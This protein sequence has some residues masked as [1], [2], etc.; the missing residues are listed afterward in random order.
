M[1]D[2]LWGRWPRWSE[3]GLYSYAAETRVGQ[4]ANLIRFGPGWNVTPVK[5]LDFSAAYYALFAP[6]S[7][8]TR[9]VGGTTLFSNRG[10]F[11][12]Q[13]VQTVLKYK[14]N[15][16]VSGHLWG[17]CLFPGDYYVSKEPIPFLRVEM[18]ITF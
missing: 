15:A 2:G 7:V 4:E 10:N 6:N 11:R 13:F 14:F 18:A 1:F 9:G 3:I 5:D 8:P 12:G 16:H 17:E